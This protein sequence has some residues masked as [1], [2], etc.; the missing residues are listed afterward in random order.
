MSI[1][2]MRE[3]DK[4]EIRLTPEETFEQEQARVEKR[5]KIEE[6][7]F[8]ATGDG[9]TPWWLPWQ[10]LGVTLPGKMTV[11]EALRESKLNDWNL[12]KVP[13]YAKTMT[14]YGE[15]HIAIPGHFAIQRQ[16]D[17]KVLGM[18]QGRYAIVSNE[19][20]FDWAKYLLGD[21]KRA[22]TDEATAYFTSAGS[23]RGGR[24]VFLVAKT[25]FDVDLENGDRLETY[26]LI[27]NRHD[28]TG[29]VTCAVIT[30]RV[31]CANT[32]ER[33]LAG[34]L[35][36]FTIRHTRRAEDKLSAAQK[37]LGL[38]R[39]AADRARQAAEHLASIEMDENKVQDFLKELFPLP[40]EEVGKRQLA[41]A[42][43]RRALVEEVYREHP[44]VAMLP[45]NGWRLYNAVTFT[46]DHM[47]Q[48]N[49]M[50]ASSRE[51]DPEGNRMLAVVGGNN[52]GTR[53][54][55]LL[56]GLKFAN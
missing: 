6:D 18:V 21:E 40:T 17:G 47:S 4:A 51:S 5:T 52:L 48:R 28:G 41:I 45:E 25:P 54:Y 53:A 29:P 42:M 27:T 1:D 44:T 12:A 34:A 36:T 26:L 13:V 56:G 9:E 3:N 24:I 43:K 2:W 20:A 38:A 19:Q 10:K 23:L 32:L 30:I 35:G 31:V 7:D 49:K 22:I 37:A 33:G 15:D 8:V 39:G 50:T 46:H 14:G 16:L 11:E 55:D